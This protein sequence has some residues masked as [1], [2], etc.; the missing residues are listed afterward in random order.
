MSEGI[1]AK[2]VI[3][4]N[5]RNYRN[6]EFCLGKKITIISGQNGVGKSNILSLISSGSGLGKKAALGSNFQPEFNEFF[7][8]DPSENFTDYKIYIQY[9]C[10]GKQDVTRR[11]SFQDYT[12]TGRG[13]RIIPR[14][15]NYGTNKT[16]KEVEAE[17]K[18]EY[19]I[20]G[21]ARVGIPTIY[22]SLSRLYPLGEK[23]NTKVSV[24]KIT[25]RNALCQEDV[26]DRFRTWYNA[27]IPNAIKEDATVEIVEKTASPRASLHMDIANTPTLSQSIGQDNVGNIISALVDI[28]LL[29]KE[30]DYAGALLC[31]DEIDVSLHPDTQI[32]ILDLIDA[33]SEQLNIQFVLSTH[34][35]T[36]LKE[37]LKK[38]AKNEEDYRVVYVKDP[39]APHVSVQDSYEL[40][41]ADMFGSLRFSKPKV[42]AYFEDEVG[43]NLFDLLIDAF[44]HIYNEIDSKCNGD[45]SI[46]VL[47]NFSNVDDFKKINEEV[48]HLKDVIHIKDRINEIPVYLGCETLID[49]DDADKYF[50]KVMIILDGDARIKNS[51]DPDSKPKIRDYLDIDFHLDPSQNIRKHEKNVCFLPD[52]FAPESF[53]YRV[54]YQLSNNA[55]EYNDFWKSVDKNEE[56]ALFTADKV[57]QLFSKL[58]GEYTNDSIK[59]IFKSPKDNTEAW[60][61]V[62]QT[63]II[64]YYYSDYKRVR[65][66]IEFIKSLYASYRMAYGN[67]ITNR[68]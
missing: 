28:Y 27:V 11:L 57:K 46:P 22:L 44:K 1:K 8:I 16:Q 61:F 24:R 6:V 47:R 10:E 63:D 39:L 36:F 25:K 17:V 38:Q 30:R 67:L 12:K 68:D 31:V 29:S 15:S 49:L 19:G 18:K 35:L 52:F 4:E 45:V 56:T 13:I 55:V 34:S 54:I 7:N 40:L 42:K 60:F 48:L 33:L 14:T 3:L 50:R 37:L 62:N 41:K 9:E 53:L 64:K 23:N 2:K 43:Q 26:R 58:S 65:V 21:A 66:L 32:K 20:G 59:E 51:K 5:F